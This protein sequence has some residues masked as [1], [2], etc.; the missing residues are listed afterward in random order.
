[1]GYHTLSK[2]TVMVQDVTLNGTT[3]RSVASC[4]VVHAGIRR[5]MLAHDAPSDESN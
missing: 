2:E 5:V 3:N 4:P 1:M